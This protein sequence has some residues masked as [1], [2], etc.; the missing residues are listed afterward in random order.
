MYSEKFI[1]ERKQ[2]LLAER[3]KLQQEIA[4]IARY[5]PD[6]GHYRPIMPEYSKGEVETLDEQADEAEGYAQHA[7]RLQDLLTTLKDIEDA[8][9]KIE[10]GK[11][12]ICEK[13]GR[14]ISE[15]RLR[16][17]PAARTAMERDES[18]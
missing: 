18:K 4:T 12:G 1:E 10:E 8:L 11:Y 2:N 9:R 3:E 17:Y 7:A 14:Y 5:N 6:T 15:E 16:I 13:T